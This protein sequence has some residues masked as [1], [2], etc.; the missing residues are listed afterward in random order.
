M[1]CMIDMLLFVGYEKMQLRNKR[2]KKKDCNRKRI[3]RQRGT[4]RG[5]KLFEFHGHDL[6]VS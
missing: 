6:Q 4:T 2:K 5:P 3:K 1:E